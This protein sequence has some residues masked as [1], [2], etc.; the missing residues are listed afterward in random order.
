MSWS[1]SV[2]VWSYHNWTSRYECLE[3]ATAICGDY[4]PIKERK[5]RLG[6]ITK[7]S[8]STLGEPTRTQKWNRSYTSNA[9]CPSE[10][11]VSPTKVAALEK[12]WHTTWQCLR[13]ERP[14][15]SLKKNKNWLGTTRLG[16]KLVKKR[17]N[18]LERQGHLS[19]GRSTTNSRGLN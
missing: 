13:W 6:A 12:T 10:R 5:Q 2:P 15:R 8:L 16:S 14:L 18:I 11:T 4:K 7:K 17:S 9:K 3:R 1:D 19:F